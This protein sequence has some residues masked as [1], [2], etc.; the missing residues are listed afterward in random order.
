[1][2]VEPT[3]L[4]LFV[5]SFGIPVSSMSRLLAAL[6]VAVDNDPSMISQ[7]VV[8]TAYMANLVEIQHERGATGGQAFYSILT[9]GKDINAQGEFWDC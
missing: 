5:Q 8:D 3:Q 4:V 2:E 7:A 6:D 9:Q 1:M